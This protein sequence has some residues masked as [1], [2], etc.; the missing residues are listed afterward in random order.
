MHNIDSIQVD[1]QL[2]GPKLAQVALTMG[3]DDID[4]VSPLE[5]DLG[6]RRSPLEEIRG[7]ITAAGLEAVERTAMDRGK[8]TPRITQ[9]T[10][11]SMSQIRRGGHVPERSATRV[12]PRQRSDRFRSPLRH[13]VGVRAAAACARDRPRVDSRR[14]NTC[15]VRE[16]Y[17]IVPGPAVTSRGPVASVAIYTRR[18]PKDIRTIAMDTSSRTSVALATVLLQRRFEWR[19]EHGADGAGA[20]RHAE[21]ADAALIIGDVA[22]FLDHEAAGAR[23]IDLGEEWTEMTGL[24]FVYACWTGWP[25]AVA[26][27]DVT[28][29][30]RARDAGV[31]QSDAVAAAYYPEDTPRQAVARRYLR[32]NIRYVLGPDEVE[33]LTDVLPLRERARSGHV[34]WKPAVL[35]CRTITELAD[36]VRAGGRVSADEALTLYHHAPLP[37][38][39]ELA[40][41]IRARKHP[42]GIVTYII[43]RNVNYTNVCVARCNFCAFYR[44]VGL[45]R[46]LRPRLRGSLQEDRR[47]DRARRRAAAAAGRAQPRSADRV[48]RGFVPR[49]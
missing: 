4:G 12:W 23:K 11:R 42:D 47:D 37:L 29:L 49:A 7:N 2:Y 24:P 25:G 1:W 44:P 8:S 5:G 46:G 40:D 33:G 3:A 28:A 35:R 39:G 43:D 17:V 34:R 20:R 38:L 22:L 26:P 13:P 10:R 36:K 31:A 48:V 9:I 32:D 18:E 14:S 41:G 27:S 45:E 21:R 15:A 6:R 19:R 16:P 30:Q